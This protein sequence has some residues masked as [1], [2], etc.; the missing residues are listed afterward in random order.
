MLMLLVTVSMDRLMFALDWFGEE[1]TD[2]EVAEANETVADSGRRVVDKAKQ[3]AEKIAEGGRKAKEKVEETGR[4]AA[5][6]LSQTYQENIARP[7]REWMNN[8][9]EESFW[10]LHGIGWP[11]HSWPHSS[12]E[13]PDRAVHSVANWGSFKTFPT[14]YIV[15]LDLPGI[16]KEEIRVV[17]RGHRLSVSGTHGTCLRG[18]GGSVDRFCLERRVQRAFNI[19]EDVLVEHVDAALKDGV[20]FI[21]LPRMEEEDEDLEEA[22]D[23]ALENEDTGS[24]LFGSTKKGK[25]T[26]KRRLRGKRV[27]VKDYKPTWK[28]RG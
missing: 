12:M 16:P 7:L 2:A 4:R 20:L 22:E 3:G 23:T 26:G 28:E 5:S 18:P 8:P 15:Y 10:P 13:H 14:E 6:S 21:R 19:P 9:S 11:G 1:E 25:A 24:W 17:C 27:P